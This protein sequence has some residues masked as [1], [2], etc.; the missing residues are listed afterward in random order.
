M[1]QEQA[2]AACFTQWRRRNLEEDS[3]EKESNPLEGVNVE[4]VREAKPY[5]GVEGENA[6]DILKE[7]VSEWLK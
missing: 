1:P 6:S 2:T 7:K 4:D 3:E 5:E